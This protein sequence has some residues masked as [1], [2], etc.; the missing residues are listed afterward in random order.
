MLL[1]RKRADGPGW[2]RW[3]AAAEEVDMN[4]PLA[5][6]LREDVLPGLHQYDG[7][8][9]VCSLGLSQPGCGLQ[10]LGLLP[11]RVVQ[12]S[13]P[14]DLRLGV[15]IDLHLDAGHLLLA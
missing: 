4:L 13:H 8:P 10:P 2:V 6:S 3:A 9:F 14:K 11:S 5:Q 1:L 12:D 15:G 7:G